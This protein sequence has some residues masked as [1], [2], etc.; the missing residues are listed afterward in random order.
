MI[1]EKRNLIVSKERMNSLKEEISNDGLCP[2]GPPGRVEAI[3][4][5]T[6]EL[7]D[8]IEYLEQEIQR[9]RKSL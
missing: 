8:Y 7:I 6:I 1:L 4:K 5:E 9:L 3:G 2:D